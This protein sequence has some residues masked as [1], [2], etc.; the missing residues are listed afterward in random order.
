MT[1][2]IA[3]ANELMRRERLETF[4]RENKILIVAALA[5]IVIL[6]GLVSFYRGWNESRNMA[7]TDAALNLIEAADFPDNIPENLADQTPSMR[8]NAKAL[9]RLSAAR[10]LLA[11]GKTGQALAQYQAAGHD[12]HAHKDLRQLGALMEAQLTGAKDTRA[13]LSAL[14]KIADDGKSPWRYHALT[15]AAVIEAHQNQNFAKARD[16]LD[17]VQKA[18][19]APPGVTARAKALR[20]VYGLR[21]PARKADKT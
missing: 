18:E 20:H 2:L 16:Y 11:Q 1:D 17:R 3:E 9:A 19:D 10:A 12:S 6:T 13:A 8:A 21:A 5:A 4:W 7:S 15:A 14:E